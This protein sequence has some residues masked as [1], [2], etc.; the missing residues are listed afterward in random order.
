MIIFNL[1]EFYGAKVFTLTGLQVLKFIST[2][3]FGAP[4]D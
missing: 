4:R 1:I 2:Y 3:V